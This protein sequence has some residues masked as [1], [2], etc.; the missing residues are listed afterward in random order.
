MTVIQKY[1]QKI[2]QRRLE[3]TKE[4][5]CEE[6]IDEHLTTTIEDFKNALEG[7]FEDDEEYEDF[8][9]WLNSYS[10]AYEDDP[11]YRAKKLVLSWGGPTDFFLFFTDTDRIEYHF[12]DWGNGAKRKLYGD[13]LK[14]MADVYG[15]LNY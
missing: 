10:L 6:R 7:K 14:V 5:T 13:D 8:I 15:Y 4:K 12:Q 3:M 9:E 11:E 1:Y 2:Y